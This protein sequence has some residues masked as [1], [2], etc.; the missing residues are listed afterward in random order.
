MDQERADR[1]NPRA[2]LIAEL[3]RQVEALALAGDVGALNVVVEALHRLVDA[4]GGEER[5]DVVDLGD[6]RRERD[7]GGK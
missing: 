1:N 7:R 5:A 3:A 2:K 6:A 4:P